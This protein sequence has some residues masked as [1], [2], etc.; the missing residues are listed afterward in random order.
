MCRVLCG[1][2]STSAMVSFSTMEHAAGESPWGVIATPIRSGYTRRQSPTNFGEFLREL[3][4]R[5]FATVLG[6][7]RTSAYAPTGTYWRP[8]KTRMQLG[9]LMFALGCSAATVN[10]VGVDPTER[11]RDEAADGWGDGSIPEVTCEGQPETGPAGSWNHSR[12]HISSNAGS[13]RHRGVD[14]I[15]T[16]SAAAQSIEGEISY[17]W[18]D[19]ALE[20]EDI[21]VFAC[22]SGHWQQIGTATTD[23]EGH[24]ALALEGD[25]RLPIGVRQMYLSVVGDRTGTDFVAFV[26]PDDT[27]I[28]FSDVDGTLTSSENAYPMS[29]WDGSEVAANEGAPEVLTALRSRHYYPVYMTARGRFFTEDTRNWLR[30]SGFPMGPLRLAPRIVTIPGDATIEYKSATIDAVASEGLIPAIGIGNRASDEAAYSSASISSDR[31]FLKSTEYAD[32]NAPLVD[33]GQAVGF[34]SYLDL[35]PTI[36]S[37]PSAH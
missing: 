17:G 4:V 2:R 29:L 7:N 21:D 26:A 1:H 34:Q 5:I 10:P 31:I 33:A 13:P 20:G 27:Q 12:S 28:V 30:D 32:E 36:E 18:A 23:D 8:M 15:T 3:L 14:L 6:R 24:F 16:A 19:K 11:G 37:I 22:R 9:L 25:D 35:L